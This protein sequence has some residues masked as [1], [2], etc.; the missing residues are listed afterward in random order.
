MKSLFIGLKP[1]IR[2]SHEGLPATGRFVDALRPA[3]D[4]LDPF[5]QNLNPVIRYLGFYRTEIT[6]FLTSPAAGIADPLA[7]GT[8]KPNLP[9]PVHALRQLG[10]FSGESLS[11]QPRRLSTNRGN[12][13]LQP[14][15]INGY[16][17]AAHG[18]FPNFDCNPSKDA[19]AANSRGEVNNQPP[20]PSNAN[21]AI[22]PRFPREFGGGQAPNL[23]AEP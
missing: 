10:Y 19:P 17:A 7:L 4:A 6:N 16:L 1:L 20:D 22:A 18:I 3:L 12:G 9:A 8:N 23:F 2:A 13:Y 5:L 11:V 15:S 21:C 14:N